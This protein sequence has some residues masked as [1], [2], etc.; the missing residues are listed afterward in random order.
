MNPYWISSRP[1]IFLVDAS[2]RFRYRSTRRLHIVE[3]LRGS[4]WHGIFLYM[5]L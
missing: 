1:A 5:T 2:R 3:P 4:S